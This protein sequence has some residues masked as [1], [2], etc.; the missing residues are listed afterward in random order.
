MTDFFF[1]R[2]EFY[3]SPVCETLF[4]M[5][6]IMETNLSEIA[7][8]G[9]KFNNLKLEQVFHLSRFTRLILINIYINI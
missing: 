7:I 3:I 9:G 4:P 5:I 8:S 2:N 6:T 1:N